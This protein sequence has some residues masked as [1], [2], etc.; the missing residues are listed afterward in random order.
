M[1]KQKLL[2]GLAIVSFAGTIAVNALA[3][4]LPINGLN[5]GQVSNR[6]PS[7]FTPD[8]TTFL[9]WNVIYLLLVGFVALAWNRRHLSV[10][11]QV[12]PWFV[13]TNVLNMAWIIV[14]HYLFIEV[15]VLIMLMLLTVL[16]RIFVTI[17]NARLADWKEKTFIRLSFVCYLAW[18][19]VATMAN[20]AA[21]LVS[22]RWQGGPLSPQAWTV[23]MMIAAASLA[24]FMAWRYNV[25]A[26]ILVVMWALL[27]IYLRWRHT[28]FTGL[29]YT[30]MMLV[31]ALGAAFI[32]L[33]RKT[34]EIKTGRA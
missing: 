33:S 17:Y 32:A 20:V 9:I 1:S 8:G 34:G 26:F 24:F 30:A 31:L 22:I 16:A 28:E 15:S 12:L 7:L 6:Y 21:L 4:L 29:I 2:A 3:N 25:P 11:Q 5:T 18:I 27:G 19:C 13:G 14:W 10:V 23:V